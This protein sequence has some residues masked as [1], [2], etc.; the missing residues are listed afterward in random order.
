MSCVLNSYSSILSAFFEGTL[1]ESLF[2]ELETQKT[3]VVAF[4]GACILV[5]GSKQTNKQEQLCETGIMALRNKASGRDG[6]ARSRGLVCAHVVSEGEGLIER[7]RGG[8]NGLCEGPEAGAHLEVSKAATEGPEGQ[9]G[10][11][12]NSLPPRRGI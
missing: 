8:R 9:R 7:D 4:H 1:C 10:D 12:S 11:S 5:E 6:T 2:Q 3:N